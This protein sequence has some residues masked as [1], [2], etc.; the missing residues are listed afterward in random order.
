MRPIFVTGIGTDVGKTLVSAILV[1]ALKADYWKPI[2]AGY[3]DG[4]DSEYISLMTSGNQ[5]RV[6]P[7]LYKL[8]MPASP[9]LA[10]KAEGIEISIEKICE[11]LPATNCQLV[12]EG[13][14]GLMVPVNK[15]EFVADLVS[16]LEADLVIVSRNYLGSINHSLLTAAV[17]KQKRLNVLG[18]IFT[19]DYGDYQQQIADWSG[20]PVIGKIP[21]LQN[22]TRA[23]IHEQAEL[24]KNNLNAIISQH[25]K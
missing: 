7:E 5:T 17:C 4:T 25:N 9:H 21:A 10:A 11:S 23:T 22:I 20:Y 19:D 6:F 12:I 1:D 15:N 2:Q 16:A 3:T 14:G 18:W 8:K 24:L 13:A